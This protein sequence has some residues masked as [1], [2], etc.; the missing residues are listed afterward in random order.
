MLMRSRKWHGRPVGEITGATLTAS[1]LFH[2]I[3]DHK[4]VFSDFPIELI[5]SSFT[6]RSNHRAN[7]GS[8]LSSSECSKI[9][10]LSNCFTTVTFSLR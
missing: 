8:E 1:L 6:N 9:T 4:L 7:I 10:G 2:V 3:D 5:F